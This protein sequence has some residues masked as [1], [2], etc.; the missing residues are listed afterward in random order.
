MKQI[1]RKNDLHG[2]ANKDWLSIW[3]PSTGLTFTSNSKAD[4]KAF[5]EHFK[6]VLKKFNVLIEPCVNHAK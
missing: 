6:K 5:Q 3:S 4:S 2:E 1:M